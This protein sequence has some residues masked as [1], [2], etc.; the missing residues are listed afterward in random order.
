MGR[1][2]VLRAWTALVLAL[3]LLPARAAGQ[4]AADSVAVFR[5]LGGVVRGTRVRGVVDRFARSSREEPC[6][7]EAGRCWSPVR[8]GAALRALAAEARL[9]LVRPSVWSTHTRSDSIP[10]LGGACEVALGVPRFDGDSVTVI[11]FTRCPPPAG[12]GGG[13]YEDD[14]M[15]VLQRAQGGWRVVAR[16][17]LRI[18]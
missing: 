8:G 14:V 12:P 1:P 3:A 5:A 18:T 16:H 7:K 11:V 9:P 13:S 2:G 4:S 17:L 10:L 6:E 15:H